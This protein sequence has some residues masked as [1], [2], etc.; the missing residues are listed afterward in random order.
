M[1]TSPTAAQR[2]PKGVRKRVMMGPGGLPST[3]GHYPETS[4]G[5]SSSGS[6]TSTSFSS[7]SMGGIAARKSRHLTPLE[8]IRNTL[9]SFLVIL[10]PVCIFLL[11]FLLSSSSSNRDVDPHDYPPVIVTLSTTHVR[12]PFLQ[13]TLDSILQQTLPPTRVYLVLLDETT[14]EEG[15]TKS[16]LWSQNGINLLEEQE[17]T[18]AATTT[19]LPQY[20]KDLLDATPPVLSVLQPKIG[21]GPLSKIVYALEHEAADRQNADADE[22]RE[23][24]DLESPLSSQETRLVYM[25]DDVQYNANLLRQLVDASLD[26]PESA[27]ALTG[28]KLRDRFRQVRYAASSTVDFDKAPNLVLHSWNTHGEEPMVVDIVQAMT[29]VCVPMALLNQTQVLHQILSLTEQQQRQD[30]WPDVSRTGDAVISGIIESQNI[31]QLLVPAIVDDVENIMHIHFANYS[32]HVLPPSGTAQ[33]NNGYDNPMEWMETVLFLQKRLGIWED[34]SFLEVGKLTAKQK[35]AIACEALHETDCFSVP[36]ACI[37]SA[38]EC[39]EA[40][41]ILS[42]LEDTATRAGDAKQGGETDNGGT[43]E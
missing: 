36:D 1:I 6:P 10:L 31:T 12:L 21:F 9:R 8:R 26:Q 35:E 38:T 5:L 7:I 13:P 40:Q 23:S 37:P 14:Q 20:L 39:P 32:T 4:L 27:V 34:H 17:D 30:Q 25:E 22:E 43:S 16:G 11:P 15:L 33:K 18:A 42:E 3:Y 28:G 29:G 24:S 19:T 2:S 41:S